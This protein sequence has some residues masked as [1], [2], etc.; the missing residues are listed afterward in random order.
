MGASKPTTI[1]T[2]LSQLINHFV[3]RHSF[4]T[5]QSLS[6]YT[7]SER[8]KFERDIYDFARAQ[9]LTKAQA[10]VQIIRARGMCGEEEYDSENSALGD[11]VDD[12]NTV[13]QSLSATNTTS[14]TWIK[15]APSTGTTDVVNMRSA[16]QVQAGPSDT[17][18]SEPKKKSQKR[19]RSPTKDSG[20]TA[21]V[22][23]LNVRMDNVGKEFR[24]EAQ[25]SP[26]VQHLSV[27]EEKSKEER[28]AIRKQ[29]KLRKRAAMT[30]SEAKG[31]TAP[32]HALA[33]K[34]GSV[35]QDSSIKHEELAK[36]IDQN[37]EDNAAEN[38][39]SPSTVGPNDPKTEAE[40]H[41]N[42]LKSIEQDPHEHGQDVNKSG[43]EKEE[44]AQKSAA[45]DADVRTL[46][47]IT[48]ENRLDLYSQ[49]KV[50]GASKEMRD[51]LKE[52]VRARK[53][54]EIDEQNDIKSDGP[55]IKKTKKK[56]SGGE[57]I[58]EGVAVSKR[59]RKSKPPVPSADLP[60]SRE[61][62]FQS[63]MIQQV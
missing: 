46:R 18:F 12:A 37:V 40:A 11:E 9:D 52:M 45:F 61:R 30:D 23:Q 28:R 48:N 36:D 32:N 16:E 51:D 59:K 4:F 3:R 57:E 58:T 29:K 41:E 6:Q 55:S 63:P 62:D 22:E 56:T 5:Q 15:D 43:E 47:D 38:I 42:F 25:D 27:D 24:P 8:R 50:K 19:K 31:D 35:A 33:A 1:S 49:G 54:M 34:G 10:N 21:K 60:R 2:R 7:S 14:S 39:I 20:K 26:T 53:E 44:V 13:M 17:N